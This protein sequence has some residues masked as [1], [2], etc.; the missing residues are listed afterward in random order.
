MPHPPD[1]VDPLFE[2]VAAE[3]E[4]WLGG[5]ATGHDLAHG[6]RVFHTAIELADSYPEADHEVLGAAALVH[7]VHRAMGA[8]RGEY[9]HPGDSLDEVAAVL[10][11]AGFPAAKREAV[12]HCVALHEEYEFRGDRRDGDRVEVDRLLDADNLDA[13]GAVGVARCFAYA[14]AHDLPMWTPDSE[15]PSAVDHFH[16]KLSNLRAEMHTEAAR[17]VAE[18]RHD[19]LEAF[20]ERFEAEW[21]GRA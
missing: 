4:G 2:A 9:V 14:G 7:D 21:F 3:V 15:A 19:F 8:K 20:L 13:T 12:L 1:D 5:D 18:E 17:E 11:A 10:E 6:W 16:E